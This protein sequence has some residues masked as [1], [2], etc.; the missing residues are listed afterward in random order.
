MTVSLLFDS[1]VA[2]GLAEG[3]FETLFSFLFDFSAR[4]NVEVDSSGSPT[5][6]REAVGFG[7]DSIFLSSFGT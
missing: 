1:I 6:P 7:F 5:T 4:E 2:E 3:P